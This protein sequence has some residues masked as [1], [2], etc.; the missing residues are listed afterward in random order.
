M[1][2]VIYTGRNLATK[3]PTDSGNAM[4][5]LANFVAKAEETKFNVFQ[6]NKDAFMKMTDVDPVMFLTTANQATQAKLLDD[7]NK[8]A[9]QIYK[10][11][12]GFP[13]MEEMQQ[14]Q[15][16]KNFLISFR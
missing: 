6:K 7:F 15:A 8:E 2:D 10:N 3:L 1:A 4:Q 16:K 14:I 5:G 12:G 11:S 13:S 9:A